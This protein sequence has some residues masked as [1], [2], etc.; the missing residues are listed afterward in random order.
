M[1]TFLYL[2]VLFICSSS[3]AQTKYTKVAEDFINFHENISTAERMYKN[4]SLLQAYARF[5]IAFSNYK[6]AINPGHYFR[7]ALCAIKIKEEFKALNFLEKAINNGYEID[8]AKKSDVVF[9]NQNTKSE[10]LANISKWQSTRDAAKNYDWTNE[11]YA[12]KEANKKF[13]TVKYTSAIEF[14]STCMK[15]KSCSKTSTDFLSKNRLVKEKMKSDSVLASTLLDKIRQFGFSSL[16]VLTKEACAIAREILLNFDADKKNEQL[17]GLLA[18]A[19]IDGNISPEYYATL[20]DRRNLMNGLTPEFYE[21]LTGY[22]KTIGKEITVA[23]NK[24]KTIGLYAIKLI[25]TTAPKAKDASVAKKSNTGL[26]D[27]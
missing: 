5:D 21:P 16:K 14:C 4:D 24:R 11:L 20:I 9:Y 13:A 25:S 3:F 27:Y 1:K 18:K 22:E 2:F 12:A 17:D 15:S 7:A 6:G 19:L 8:S 26:Y 10:Y 23:N